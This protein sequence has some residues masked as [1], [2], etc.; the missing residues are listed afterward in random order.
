[1]D[2][3]GNALCWGCSGSDH[4]QCTPAGGSFREVSTGAWHTCGV[5][6]DGD[7]RCWGALDEQD[8]GQSSPPDLR[9]HSVSAG[10]FHTCGITEDDEVVCWGNDEKGQASPSL[11]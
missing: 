8:Y 3:V 4:G 11:E 2:D 9:F 1:M 7:V 10:G 5:T 6:E